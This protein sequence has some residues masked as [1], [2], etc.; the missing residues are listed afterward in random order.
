MTFLFKQG[1]GDGRIYTAAH[2]HRDF[3]LPVP[4]DKIDLSPHAHFIV[5]HHR[6]A[7]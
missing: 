5:H 1:S 6:H 4:P 2:C 7:G 3:Q